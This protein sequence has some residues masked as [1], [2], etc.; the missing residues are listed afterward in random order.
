MRTQAIL[1]LALFLAVGASAQEASKSPVQA[2][3]GFSDGSKITVTR[4]L[5]LK[6]YRFV[7]DGRLLAVKGIQVPAGDYA[8]SPRKDSSNNWTLTMR[9]TAMK[10]G[11]WALPPL[12]MSV[13][14]PSRTSGFPIFFDHTGGS[15][16]LYW[17]EKKSDLVLSLEFTKENTDVPVVN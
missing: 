15:C 7:T 3:C 8:V 14:T 6:S 5:D 9:K 1:A 12:P 16:M 17:S 2:Q 13:T 4:S 11:S 10:K